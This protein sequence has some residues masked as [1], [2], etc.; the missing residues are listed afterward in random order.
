MAT[1]GLVADSTPSG[2]PYCCP[3]LRDGTQFYEGTEAER[4][5]DVLQMR[6]KLPE[7]RPKYH[8]LLGGEAFGD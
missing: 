2:C 6:S 3:H 1:I 5:H 8:C 7:R 4:W